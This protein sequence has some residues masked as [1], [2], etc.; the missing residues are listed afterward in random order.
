MKTAHAVTFLLL[1]STLFAATPMETW[2]QT[3]FGSPLNAGNGA[4]NADPDHD[5]MSNIAE[6]KL[7]RLPNVPDISG[8]VTPAIIG[9]LPSIVFDSVKIITDVDLIPQV[10]SDL[11]H[12]R[13]GAGYIT[14]TVTADLGTKVRVQAS[15]VAF[16]G[17]SV[18]MRLFPVSPSQSLLSDTLAA[19]TDSVE[20]MLARCQLPS[21]LTSIYPFSG[22]LSIYPQN[23]AT[24]EPWIDWYFINIGLCNF[25]TDHPDIVKAYMQRYVDYVAL[26]NQT[27]GWNHRIKRVTLNTD[28]QTVKSYSDSDSD[29]AYASTF[30]RLACLFRKA[31]PTDPWFAANL[32]ELK[33]LM[34]ANVI[35]QVR[36]TGLARAKQTGYDI[37]FLEDNVE[38]WAALKELVDALVAVGDLSTEITYYAAWRDAILNAIHTQMW[39]AGKNAWKASDDLTMAASAATA[40]FNEDLHCQIFPE[41][42]DMPHPSG[43]AETQR[44]YDGAWAWLTQNKQNWWTDIWAGYSYSTLDMAVVASKRGEKD[45][46]KTYLQTVISRWIPVGTNPRGTVISEIGYWKL[47]L[48]E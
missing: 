15:V 26:L 44:R 30:V 40:K 41:L 1:A 36:S 2:R 19:Q 46:A 33:S 42:Y 21:G 34:Y 5:G 4:D 32:P 7:G 48:T 3:Y 38:N 12:W 11:L 6:A 9:G 17:T 13:S 8:A 45:H 16:S 22:A 24:A 29:D 14:S 47:L 18:F 10:S 20:Q 25:V 37:G 27:P 43:S 28:H 35:T 31:N 23:D 39:D